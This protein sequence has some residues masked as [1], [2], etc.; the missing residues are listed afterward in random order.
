MPFLEYARDINLLSKQIL[1]EVPKQLVQYFQSKGI[2]P[3]P[4]DPNFLMQK[5]ATIKM[6]ESFFEE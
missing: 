2:K 1:G 3:N 6:P 4:A 5:R